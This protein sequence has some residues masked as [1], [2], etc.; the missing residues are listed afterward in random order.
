MPTDPARIKQ[1]G[2][3]GE[4]FLEGLC[5]G[6]NLSKS[7]PGRDENGWDY[8]IEVPQNR[9]P[10]IHLDSQP[11]PVK[12]LCQVKSTDNF[13]DRTL[14]MKVSNWEHLS[15]TPLPSFVLIL[16]YRGQRQPQA[17]YLCHIDQNRMAQTLKRIREL[18]VGG[19][20]DLHKH[21]MTLT[22]DESEEVELSESTDFMREVRKHTGFDL[23]AYVNKK[24]EWLSTLGYETGRYKFKFKTDMKISDLVDAALNATPFKIAD[25]T[26]ASSRFG[27]DIGLENFTSGMISI[28][29]SPIGDCRVV[30]SSREGG[31]KA[32]ITGQVIAPL[33]WPAPC[34]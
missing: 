24:T 6:E 5:I 9:I 23:S 28:E 19:S 25:A 14:S 12:F 11:A 22:A 32:A 30:A 20:T 3:L 29:P 26:I 7:K 18:E 13:E 4:H 2:D 16:D 21:E 34:G 1:L 8:F 33:I 17:K 27:I 31:G 10:A 15:K